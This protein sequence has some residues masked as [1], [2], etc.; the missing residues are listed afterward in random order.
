MEIYFESAS[1]TLE[2]TLARSLVL[3]LE[4]RPAIPRSSML[5]R[6]ILWLFYFRK[7]CFDTYHP[8]MLYW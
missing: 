8:F 4:R 3:L 6:V 7:F 1:F 5:T 2:R